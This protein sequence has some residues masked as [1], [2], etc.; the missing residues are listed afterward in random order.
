MYYY[1]VTKRLL[2]RVHYNPTENKRVNRKPDISSGFYST[3]ELTPRKDV[4]SI[5]LKSQ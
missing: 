1:F 2:M 3:L 5:Q 4:N